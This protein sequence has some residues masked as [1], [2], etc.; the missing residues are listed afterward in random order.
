MCS[1][2]ISKHSIAAASPLLY[3]RSPT[4]LQAGRLSFP[5]I[6]LALTESPQAEH[7]GFESRGWGW[8][9]AQ[10][11]PWWG[12][13]TAGVS[14]ERQK[15]SWQSG[16]GEA[17]AELWGGSAD[18]SSHPCSWT[19]ALLADHRSGSETSWGQDDGSPM[20]A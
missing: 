5:R 19:S 9:R 2:L 3:F 14:G 18:L 1:T 12:K 13:D 15:L 10:V 16:F 7:V 8:G 17:Q 20:N 11:S 6:V 4:I